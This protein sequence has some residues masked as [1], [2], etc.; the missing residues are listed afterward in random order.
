MMSRQLVKE[1]FDISKSVVRQS[2]QLTF[3]LMKPRIVAV[4]ERQ[5]L[6]QTFM[7]NDRVLS[8]TCDKSDSL[9]W[10]H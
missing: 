1:Y 4:A 7:I 3:H 6:T 10:H 2:D 8:H 5:A 9:S